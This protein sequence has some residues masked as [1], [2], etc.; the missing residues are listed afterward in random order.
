MAEMAAVLT[1]TAYVR[2]FPT[3]EDMVR[4]M[5]PGAERRLRPRKHSSMHL[6]SE[7]LVQSGSASAA[8]SSGNVISSSTS[9]GTLRRGQ[10]GGGGSGGGRSNGPPGKSSFVLIK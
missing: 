8:S 6:A 9:I 1:M 2:R 7:C 5:V 10:N 4:V 3:I